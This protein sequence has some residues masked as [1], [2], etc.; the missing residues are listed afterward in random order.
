MKTITRQMKTIP[1][2]CQ[3][4]RLMRQ[5]AASK[6]KA[7]YYLQRRRGLPSFDRQDAAALNSE[8]ATI[9]PYSSLL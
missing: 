1:P 8:Y 4:G 7:A 9:Q 6:C 3:H 2:S 5:V